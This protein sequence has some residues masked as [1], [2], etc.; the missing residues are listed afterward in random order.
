[1][2][3]CSNFS[4]TYYLLDAG[5]PR[6]TGSVRRGLF[7]P[8]CKK[9]NRPNRQLE[10]EKANS[11]SRKVIDLRQ[12]LGIGRAGAYKLLEAGKIQSFKIGNTYKI[13][14]SA[15]IDY[16]NQ[17]CPTESKGGEQE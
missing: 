17:Q 14:K 6:R 7:R 1:M 4:A 12:A 8:V 15:L 3:I 13:P 9:E 2:L 10:L 16:V 11:A 5:K